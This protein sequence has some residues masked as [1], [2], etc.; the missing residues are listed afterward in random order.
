MQGGIE[1]YPG[2][3]LEHGQIEAAL[4]ESER[5]LQHLADNLPNALVYQVTAEP[6]G[7]RRFTY[8][9]RGIERLMGV[10]AEEVLADARA[11]YGLI[12]P[13]YLTLTRASEEEALRAQTPLR[14]EVQCLLPGDRLRWFRFT[15]TPRVLPD[16]L[17]VWDGVAVDITELKDTEAELE[18]RVARR[19][20]ELTMANRRLAAEIEERARIQETLRESEERYRHLLDTTDTGF[21]VCDTQGVLLSANAAYVRMAGAASLD[22]IAGHP[23]TCWTAPDELEKNYAALARCLGHGRIDDFETVYSDRN[24]A[25]T[26]ISITATLRESGEGGQIVLFCRNITERKQ[27]EKERRRLEAQVRQAQ[28]LES[29]G[30]LAGGIAHDFNNILHIILGNAQHARRFIT[31]ASPARPFL[32]NIETAANRAGMLTRQMLAYAGKGNFLVQAVDLA[33]LVGEMAHL[34][35]S[36]ASKK[37]LLRLH[38]DGGL[39]AVEADPSQIQQVAMNL[40]LNATEALDPDH[41]GEVTVSVTAARQT[42]AQLRGNRTQEQL[43]PG[44]YVCLEVSDTGCGMDG[45][46]LDRLFD[47]FFTTKFTGR[48]LGMPAVLGIARGHRGGVLVESAPGRGTTVRALFPASDRPVPSAPGVPEDTAGRT[49]ASPGTILFVDDEPEM[50]EL[51]MM[52]LEENGYTVVTAGDGL[53]ALE[54][55]K[56]APDGIDCV[57]LDLCMPRMDGVEAL[58]EMRRIKPGIRVLLASGYAEEEVRMRLAGQQ[59]DALLQ[60]PY[61]FSELVEALRKIME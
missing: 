37:V 33:A 31:D 32:G 53:Q 9:S 51:G 61:Q 10:T 34:I 55:L 24:G 15:S 20:V 47:P 25:R 40:I 44:D 23:V 4:R 28:K 29:L 56:A 7:G 6:D 59:V 39:P 50:L 54:T 21:A 42:E 60:K 3:T 45:D 52:A 41:G 49:A 22:E 18:R 58:L 8:V 19:T 12:L 57:L 35:Q 1:Q 2:D 17:L 11:L 14:V 26:D 13:E 38:L 16:G 48:G 46:T 5:R 36:S 27:A 30:V 43:P